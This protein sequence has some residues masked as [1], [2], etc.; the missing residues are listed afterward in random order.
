MLLCTVTEMYGLDVVLGGTGGGAAFLQV[1]IH[2][3]TETRKTGI[4]YH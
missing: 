2:V 1:V 3:E 4:N